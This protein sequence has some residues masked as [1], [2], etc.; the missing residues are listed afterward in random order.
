MVAAFRNLQVGVVTRGQLNALFRHQAQER[1]VLRFWYVMVN[2]FQNLLIAMR[3]GDFQHFRVYFTDLIDFRAQAAG[4]DHLAIFSQRFTNRFQRLLYG[5][6]DKATGIDD[7]HVG[8]VI[9]RYDVIAFGTQFSQDSLRINQVFRAAQGNEADFRLAG[10]IAHS[11][12][13]VQL[14]EWPGQG[15]YRDPG[16]KCIAISSPV[17][18]SAP[19]GL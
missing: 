19:R 14:L 6:V 10:Y 17:R 9:A 2:V 12:K 1:V 16:K 5:T 4:D 18:V 13:I 3:P 8:V 11:L 15:F 7:H